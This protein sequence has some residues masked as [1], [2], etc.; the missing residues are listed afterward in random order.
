MKREKLFS[1]KKKKQFWSQ[2]GTIT[3]IKNSPKGFNIR[4]ELAEEPTNLEVGQ[5]RLS[6]PKNVDK[7]NEE[8]LIEP[9]RSG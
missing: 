8:K 2:K 6:R 9:Q 1:K 7:K 5:L 3:E 4:F